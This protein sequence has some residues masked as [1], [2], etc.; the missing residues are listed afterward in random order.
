MK[1]LLICMVCLILGTG[2]ATI[3][4]AAEVEIVPDDRQQ[5]EWFAFS[6]SISEGIAIAG[7][8]FKGGKGAAYIAVFDKGNWREQVKLVAADL[9]AENWFGF[10]VSISE[11]TAIIGAP[12][13]SLG[14]VKW[15][16]A[17]YIFERQGKKEW[18]EKAKLVAEDAVEKAEF[19]HSVAISG[20]TAIVG[21][22]LDP[23]DGKNKAGSAYI[24]V[25][26]RGQWEQQ[27]KLTPDD[28][29]DGKNFGKSVAIHKHTAIVGAHLDNHSGSKS[30]SAYIFV[31]D[32]NNWTQQAKLTASDAAARD[33]FGISV[34][35]S[36]STAIVGSP[37]DD[38]AG[39]K[40]GSAY[41]FGNNGGVWT[42]RAK[43]TAADAAAGD[44]FGNA[45]A[46]DANR[47]II[48]ARLHDGRKPD[49]GAVYAFSRVAGAWVEQS[50]TIHKKDAEAD[51]FGNAVAISEDFAII[52]AYRRNL[53]DKGGMCCDLGV[54]G[55]SAYIFHTE[56]DLNAPLSV[57]PS[58]L[59]TTTLGL[60][61]R[62]ALFQ[63]FP[64]P[65]NPETWIPY[66]LAHDASVNIRIYDIQGQLVRQMGMGQQPAGSYLTREA[67]AYWDGK[68]QLG[69]TV[70]SGV[71]FYTLKA[72]TFQATRR[73]V[74]LK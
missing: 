42:E 51:E 4:H 21:A 19:G 36:G 25:S 29:D 7:A 53:P 8:P 28:A 60:V 45:V 5:G 65:F 50:K 33:E 46:V 32:G 37:F 24:F 15:T 68:D 56:E 16:G 44:G 1:V 34:G 43:L 72:D 58:L 40:S 13:H 69:E 2:M 57:E 23:H 49:S 6:V 35:I 55:G 63:N 61:K 41:I 30:G 64:N 59:M 9:A 14:D 17:A 38:D 39:S 22:Y 73:M 12:L 26:E 62:N 70:S 48:G 20:D 27:A 10:S 67:A 11:G 31:R 18:K 52:G 3:I 71:Y 47:A 74:I 54:D 66:A